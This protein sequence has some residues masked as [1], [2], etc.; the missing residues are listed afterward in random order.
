VRLTL[1]IDD[2]RL[3]D[4]L[5]PRQR[6]HVAVGLLVVSGVSVAG[7]MSAVKLAADSLSLIQLMFFR[8]ATGA[9]LC[10]PMLMAAS[11]PLFPRGVWRLYAWRI[12]LTVFAI[13]GWLYSIA[14]L[15]LATASAL[16]FSKGL[17]AL[18]LAAAMLGERL[19]V[20]K[21]AATMVGFGGV[22]LVLGPTEGEMPWLAG[23]AGIMG[24]CVGAA[25]TVVI[26]RLSASE[27]T[28]RMMFYPLAA[29]GALLAL[30]AALVWR[31]LTIETAGLVALM[32]VC[33]LVSQWCFL[34]A[35]RL[36]EVSELAPVEYSRL[37]VAVLAGFALFG[38]VPS[39][40]AVLDMALIVAATLSTVRFAR[41]APAPD[42]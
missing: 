26:K 19:T 16:T 29:M 11:M 22:L 18:W 23:I 21:I 32:I 39:L 14:H 25:L 42:P 20:G 28:V 5:S 34:N 2:A 9:L 4:H 40:W 36:G 24:A 31:P 3:F 30:P 38:E 1:L 7:V 10:V 37:A 33:G 6:H 17:F 15:P 12:A 35:Y 27:P 8:S 13:G 41:P